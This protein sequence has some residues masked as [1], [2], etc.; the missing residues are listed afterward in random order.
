MKLRVLHESREFAFSWDNASIY[1]IHP[2]EIGEGEMGWYNPA[3]DTTYAWA[4][5]S[6][7][8]MATVIHR[9]LMPK[10]E[11]EPPTG[12][13]ISTVGD[14]WEGEDYT[15]W[16]KDCSDGIGQGWVWFDMK[17]PPEILNL[18]GHTE[19]VKALLLHLPNVDMVELQLD[20]GPSG[21]NDEFWRG[22]PRDFIRLGL[23]APHIPEKYKSSIG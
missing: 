9:A 23:K 7:A 10:P 20:G 17:A 12:D 4:K 16:E 2:S 15:A 11:P 3:D 1:K 5:P 22:N 18:W 13:G 14:R 19:S 21:W 6:D 8:A